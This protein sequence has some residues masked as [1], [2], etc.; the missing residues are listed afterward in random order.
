MAYF[1][2]ILLILTVA[3]GVVALVDKLFFEKARW[4]LAAQDP[5]FVTLSRKA[6]KRRVKAP[7]VADYCRSLFVVFL[8]VLIVR[9]FLVE[10]F[11]IPSG[12]ML[13]TLKIGDF[14]TVNKHEYGLRWPVWY[15]AITTPHLPKRGDVI[16]FHSTVNPKL[17]LIK[18]VI[19]LPGD[20]ISY[21]DRRLTINGHKVAEKYL[22]KTIEPAD[23]LVQSVNE[24]QEDL[25]GV[26]H[27]I[28]T[29]PWVESENF[30]NLVVPAG[31]VFVMGDNRD[32]SDDSRYW[33]FVPQRN[34]IGEATNIWLSWDENNNSI[35]WR[36]FGDK[37]N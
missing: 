11:R 6:R 36:R 5:E 14:I 28:Y 29:M 16:V 31:E 35:R 33:G 19:G 26:V 4:Q 18:R 9:S 27:N 22:G 17:D 7:L 8:I 20:H 24:Y 30:K 32:N 15:R 12:S 21:V 37:I 10:P 13:P 3:S 2:L 1:E 34:I 25:L 23:S